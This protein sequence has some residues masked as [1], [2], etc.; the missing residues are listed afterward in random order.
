LDRHST[1]AECPARN[2]HRLAG[3][4][5]VATGRPA[6]AVRLSAGAGAARAGAGRLVAGDVAA[7]GG[8]W[9]RAEPGRLWPVGRPAPAADAGGHLASVAADGDAR[10]FSGRLIMAARWLAV[11]VLFLAGPA[12][13]AHD[14]PPF[15]LFMDEKA[16]AY[17]VSVW[18]DPD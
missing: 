3:P 15:P 14:G 2:G 6:G 9:P 11:L 1:D 8:G 10:H 7:C 5:D 4:A 12:L 17:K 18:T 13:Y 16:G